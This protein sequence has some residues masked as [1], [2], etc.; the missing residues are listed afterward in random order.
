MQFSE[1]YG[2]LESNLGSN[3]LLT[4]SSSAKSKEF[5]NRV[6]LE[7]ALQY[8]FYEN[9]KTDTGSATV[10]STATVAVP[11]GARRILT[12]R[13]TS[14]KIKL[15]K[16]DIDWYEDQDQ[17][18]DAEGAPEYWLRYGTN[19]ILWPTPDDAYN[20]Q[21]RYKTLPT[22]LS[23]D[24]DEPFFPTEWHGALVLLATS[25]AAFWL[26][27]DTKAMNFKSEGLGLIAGISEDPGMDDLGES[28]QFAIRRTRRTAR[29]RDWPQVP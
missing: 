15:K 18:S 1:I 25:R 26:G 14:N 4:A 7:M 22:A 17:S 28:G 10:A 23:A 12:V 9:Q 21:I 5:V 27:L 8:D 11:T 16:R 3:A 19:I 29:D 20:L 6:Y 13:D 24:G 2:E